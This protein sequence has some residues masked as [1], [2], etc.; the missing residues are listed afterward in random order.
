MPKPE[1][2]INGGLDYGVV[3][4]K[5]DNF[6]ACSD[7]TV[8]KTI[9]A[10]HS[11]QQLNSGNP[12]TDTLTPGTGSD[13]AIGIYMSQDQSIITV[14]CSAYTNRSVDGGATFHT[15][16]ETW[17]TTG[18]AY[19]DPVG[20]PPASSSAFTG[21]VGTIVKLT[22]VDTY[23][24]FSMDQMILGT[25]SG[26][27]GT[28]GVASTQDGGTTWSTMSGQSGLFPYGAHFH[29]PSNGYVSRGM[30]VYETQDGG[31]T[32]NIIL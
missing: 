9:D 11:W 31:V 32:L 22:W 26:G 5:A 13:A 19:P 15:I 28:I 8:W 30:H 23:G 10:G 4:Q 27:P 7:V 1:L 20:C 3:V 24:A 29:S 6:N 16:L 17:S 12:L 21:S 14:T 2:D 25:K 18:P